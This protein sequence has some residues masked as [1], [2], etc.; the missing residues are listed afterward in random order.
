MFT[1]YDLVAI[2]S[3]PTKTKQTEWNG[4]GWQMGECTNLYGLFGCLNS[5]CGEVEM[6]NLLLPAILSSPLVIH[7]YLH[8]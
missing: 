1:L 8:G 6:N 7:A 2:Q 3:V 4:M 5:G